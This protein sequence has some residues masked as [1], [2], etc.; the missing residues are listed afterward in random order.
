MQESFEIDNVLLKYIREE[1]LTPEETAMLAAWESRDP[2]RKEL[3]AQMRNGREWALQ[4]LSKVQHID[5]D[6]SWERVEAMIRADGHWNDTPAS[7]VVP[8]GTTPGI[9]AHRSGARP[10]LV[11]AAVVLTLGAAS[12][13]LMAHRPAPAV[14]PV[15]ASAVASDIRPGGNRATLTLADGRKINLDSSSNGVLAAQQNMTVSKLAAGQLA[16]KGS[17]IEKP[18]PLA[19]NTLST[20]KAGQFAL[21]LADGTRVWLNNASTL[22]Y[23]VAFTGSDRAVDL[24]GEAYFEVARDPAHPFHVIVHRVTNPTTAAPDHPSTIEVLGTAFNVM[25]YSDEP[26]EQAT[27]LSGSIRFT[28]ATHNA[29]LRPGQQSVLDDKGEVHVS[30]HVNIQDVIAWKNGFFHFDNSSLEKTMRQLGRWYDVDIR[31]E[32]QATSQAFLGHGRI[33][34][35]LPLSAILHGLENDHVHFTLQGRSLIVNQQ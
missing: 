35:D 32:G 29:L 14:A 10:W 17:S 8:I 27:L 28:D 31:Y 19:F 33:Q 9:P 4:N 30:S 25:A 6:G 7:L 34:R 18:G 3:L 24:Y 15:A 1:Q 26:D 20:P 13:W 2:A 11:A 5:K 23:P 22:R 21:T 12:W 16:Y